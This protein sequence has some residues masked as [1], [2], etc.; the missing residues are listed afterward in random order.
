M[1]GRRKQRSLRPDGKSYGLSMCPYCFAY[2]CDSMAMSS[3]FSNRIH[4]RLRRGECPMC[5]E[6][7]SFCRCKS[8]EQLPPGARTIR[9]HNNKKLR[10]A[11]EYIEAQE[12]AY[13]AW[14]AKSEELARCLGDK[15]YGEIWRSLRHHRIP[16]VD[17]L[18]ISRKCSSLDLAVIEYGWMAYG[19]FVK[20]LA[21]GSVK[22]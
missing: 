11:R 6:P 8:S 1:R 22:Y 2:G 15:M 13:R 14:E 18:F 20:L 10:Q 9:T 5:G 17:W 16:D 3:A 21:N 12:A 4:E 7:K 19:I